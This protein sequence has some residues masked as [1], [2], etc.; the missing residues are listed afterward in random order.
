MSAPDKF[1]QDGGVALVDV[2]G[3][4]LNA[5]P[6]RAAGPQRSRHALFSAVEVC[7]R[8]IGQVVFMNHPLCG[9]LIL[10]GM[11]VQLWWLALFTLIGVAAGTGVGALEDR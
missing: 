7:L 6:A 11:A 8:G 1:D 10:A 9:A 5:P 4:F 2:L 3:E